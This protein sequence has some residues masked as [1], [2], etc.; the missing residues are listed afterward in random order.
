MKKVEDLLDDL[1]VKAKEVT[2]PHDID[3]LRKE[4]VR[5]RKLLE[6]YGIEDEMHITNVE[7]I[8]QKTIDD[9][10]VL[11]MNGGMDS[12]QAKVFDLMHKNLR[13]ARGNIAKKETPGKA[14]SEA[15]LLRIVSDSK[16]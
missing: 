8:C 15:E 16:K 3:S 9:L 2:L 12:D 10:K 4:V 13:M 7:Y 1:E 14:S 11:T 5:L 6:T